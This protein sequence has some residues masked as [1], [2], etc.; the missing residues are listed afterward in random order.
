MLLKWSEEEDAELARIIRKYGTSDWAL[1][2]K[3][4]RSNRSRDSVIKRWHG[5]LKYERPIEPEKTKKIVSAHKNDAPAKRIRR[6][7]KFTV[8][9]RRRENRPNANQPRSSRSRFERLR[10]FIESSKA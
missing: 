3:H 9:P 7:R 5:K 4:F 2:R 1:V 10:K 8:N 6:S